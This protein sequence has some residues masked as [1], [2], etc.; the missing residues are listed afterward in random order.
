[1]IN[2][3]YNPTFGEQTLV[4]ETHIF[5]FNRDIYGKPIKVNL[6]KFL[7][8][9]EKYANIDELATQISKDVSQAK[10]ILAETAVEGHRLVW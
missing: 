9:E 8:S 4:A 1:V 10:Q 6:I 3:G 2:I 7:R 5:D